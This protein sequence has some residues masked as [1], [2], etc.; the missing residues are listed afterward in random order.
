MNFTLPIHFPLYAIQSTILGHIAY[1][2]QLQILGWDTNLDILYKVGE[3]GTK[4]KNLLQKKQRY[5][6][7]IW[8]A[9]KFNA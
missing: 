7:R 2:I 8:N 6:E 1:N 3:N 5:N 4:M 9:R